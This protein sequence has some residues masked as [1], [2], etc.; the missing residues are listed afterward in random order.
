M[1][2]FVYFRLKTKFVISGFDLSFLWQWTSTGGPSGVI[3]TCEKISNANLP[4]CLNKRKTSKRR[5]L[6]C[7]DWLSS[8]IGSRVMAENWLKSCGPFDVVAVT[9]F[10]L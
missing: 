4:V 2:I 10:K 8:A 5:I 6:R 7:I 9:V 3:G 1:R